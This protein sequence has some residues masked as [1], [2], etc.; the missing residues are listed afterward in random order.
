MNGTALDEKAADLFAAGESTNSVAN[1]LYNRNWKRA[2]EQRKLWDALQG[3]GN[4]HA[5]GAALAIAEGET[6]PE[7]Q[8]WELTLTIPGKQ[9]KRMLAALNVEEQAVAI[10]AVLQSR[11]DEAN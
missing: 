2:K 1:K 3:N 8:D 6:P 4:G 11:I 9:F 10:Q 5:N 7:Q